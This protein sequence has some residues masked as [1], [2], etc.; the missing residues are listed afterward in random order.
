MQNSPARTQPGSPA[1]PPHPP[2]TKQ[3]QR[4]IKLRCHN[5][6]L[7]KLQPI[8]FQNGVL[9][10]SPAH[11]CRPVRSRGRLSR[12]PQCPCKCTVAQG[13]PPHTHAKP[14]IPPQIPTVK[15][16]VFSTE[17]I[18]FSIKSISCT[19]KSISFIMKSISST[20]KTRAFT[21]EMCT[22]KLLVQ[23]E[24]HAVHSPMQSTYS[25]QSTSQN[26]PKKQ[27]KLMDL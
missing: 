18:I 2:A 1:P 16:I 26:G 10:D 21:C 22:M 25:K 9:V 6:S 14:R 7:T 27:C 11:L 19:M 5:Q 8:Q 20:I 4:S 17:S 15:T 13:I 24:S 23:V 12:P 3:H